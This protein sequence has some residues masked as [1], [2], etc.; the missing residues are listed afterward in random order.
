MVYHPCKNREV[1][2]RIEEHIQNFAQWVVVDDL[3]H[4]KRGR[5]ISATTAFVGSD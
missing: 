3:N 2:M 5:R 1:G 4:L